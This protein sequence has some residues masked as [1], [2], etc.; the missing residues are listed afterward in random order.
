MAGQGLVGSVWQNSVDVHRNPRRDFCKKFCKK[1]VATITADTVERMKR[2][3]GATAY[4]LL[5]RNCEHIANYIF[6]GRWLSMQSL[7]E[8]ASA[9]GCSSL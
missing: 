3:V 4:S 9:L 1:K 2:V 6:E 7:T 5:L 8:D